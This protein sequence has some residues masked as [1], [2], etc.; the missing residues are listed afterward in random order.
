MMTN[1]LYWD[2]DFYQINKSGELIPGD[3][4]KYDRPE[5]DRYVAV[6]SDGL[7]SGVKAH[8]LARLTS[9]MASGLVSGGIPVESAVRT[10]ADT[11]PVCNVRKI[12]YSTFT[13][14]EVSEMTSVRLIEYDNP[15]YLL[16]RRGAFVDVKKDHSILKIGQAK[17]EEKE[18]LISH[19]KAEA[20]DRIIFFSDGVTQ[21]GLGRNDM[22]LGWEQEAACEFIKQTIL[23]NTDISSKRLARA[24]CRE[25]LKN[26]GYEAHDDISC[27]VLWLR[28]SR[29]AL[30][31]SGPPYHDNRDRELAARVE[32]FDGPVFV[33][34]GT[35][36]QIV[37]RE[38]NREI[39][40]DLKDIHAD[41]PPS[42]K[43]DGVD[44]VTE[45]FLTLSKVADL[46]ES[47]SQLE[48]K[49]ADPAV[50]MTE[51]LLDC[52]LISFIVGTKINVA[53]QD[54]NMPEEI[55][56]RRTLIK[57]IMKSLK[58][59]YYKEVSVEYF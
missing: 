30:V 17:H 59:D 10:I 16:F 57:R 37:A 48:D 44:M 43:M 4:Y 19:I 27:G 45:G 33:A 12:S 41:V 52:D 46:L 6:L 14:A 2:I 42:S 8:V 3:V 15:P 35:T 39:E 53:H 55:E 26:D 5:T 21:S 47:G 9:Q 28:R 13:V 34:G 20:G 1:N 54:P 31:V 51:K 40:V 38:L 58:N 36:A 11:L 56:L 22:P 50:R 25:A 24:I 49:K 29:S 23:G 18:V 7:G 32:C